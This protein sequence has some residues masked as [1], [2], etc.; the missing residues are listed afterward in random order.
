MSQLSLHAVP[1]L[2]SKQRVFQ[3]LSHTARKAPKALQTTQPTCHATGRARDERDVY[4]CSFQSQHACIQHE[5][6]DISKLHPALQQQWDHA[7]NA[8]LGNIVIKPHSAKKVRWT[9]DQCPDGHLHTWSARVS[10]RTRGDGCPQ[11][12]SRQVCKHNSLAT[13]APLVAA[14]WD[15]K[16]NSGTPDDVVA[17]SNHKANWHCKLCGCKWEATPNARVS[18]KKTGCPQCGDHARTK[19][20]TTHPTFAECKHP[21]LAEW[22]FDRN[23]AQGHF[24]DKVRLRSSKKIFWLCTKCPAGQKHSWSAAP[25]HRTGRSHAGCPFCAGMA[26]CRCNSLQAL[27]PETAAEWDYNKNK[28]LASHYTLP[29]PPT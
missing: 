9:C 24:P 18:K 1:V 2:L 13:K 17:Q 21:L 25:Y 8:H 16:A 14:Q 6:P 23:A 4:C 20:R 22:D 15:Y 29:A 27:F 28:G 11:C 12:G 26:A 19:K 10:H 5:G 7:A 3:R